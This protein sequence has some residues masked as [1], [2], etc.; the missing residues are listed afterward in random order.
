MRRGVSRSNSSLDPASAD[1]TGTGAGLGGGGAP[2]ALVATA[3]VNTT[4][5]RKAEKRGVGRWVRPMIYGPCKWT[6]PTNAADATVTGAAVAVRT[7]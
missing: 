7:P 5:R 2:N 4:I 1:E 6:S 3:S